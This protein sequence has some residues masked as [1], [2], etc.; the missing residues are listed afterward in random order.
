MG[1]RRPPARSSHSALGL[2]TLAAAVLCAAVLA[3]AGIHALAAAEEPEARAVRLGLPVEAP[4]PAPQT[5][6]EPRRRPPQPVAPNPPRIDWRN[7]EAVGT[8][9]AGRLRHGVALP[10]S[11][12]YWVSWDPVLRRSP[13]RRWRRFG[14]D[15][16]LRTTLAIMREFGAAHPG[17]SRV[18]IGD[19]SRP[20][21]GEF[22]PRWGYIGHVTHQ[23]GLD[24]DVYYPRSDGRE[25]PPESVDQVDVGLAQ[26]LVDRFVA[27]G[28]ETVYVGPN[29]PLEGPAGIV[30]PAANHD[31]H[32]HARLPPEG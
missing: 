4:R 16:L 26:E 22:G 32:L 30:I 28:A 20:R 3:G 9:E 27:A 14:T 1:S 29:L 24:I 21:G 25:K 12:R 17:A 13:S 6:D 18:A 15:R 11:G 31:N 19:L 23:N 8:P 10:A 5:G 2:P 7:S